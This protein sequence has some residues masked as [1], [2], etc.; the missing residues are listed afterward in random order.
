MT[1][2]AGRMRELINFQQ[3]AP[4][5]DGYGN[6]VAGW[7]TVLGPFYARI[8]PLKGVEQMV[9]QRLSGVSDY[10]I[11]VGSI[12][13]LLAV[14]TEWRIQHARTGVTYNIIATQN[15]DERN[16]QLAFTVKSGTAEA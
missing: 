9:D 3:R 5:I 1:V 7:A 13:A 4:V 6:T 10:E 15:P 2:H 8:R 14:T 12:A 16:A 11:T